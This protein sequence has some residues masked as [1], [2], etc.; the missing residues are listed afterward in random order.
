MLLRE[1]LEEAAPGREGFLLR[2]R[3]VARLP[4]QRTQ[5]RE[6]PVGVLVD[7]L[8]ELAVAADERRA[9]LRREVDAE[10]RPRLHH[11][12]HGDRLLLALR[13]DRRALVEVKRLRRRAIRRLADED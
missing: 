8:L 13:L 3:C 1:R 12:P 4:D 2:A 11:L 7:Q 5:V 10:A 6:H 9:R